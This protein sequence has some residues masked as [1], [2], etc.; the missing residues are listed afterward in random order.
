MPGSVGAGTST[1]VNRPGGNHVDL[2]RTLLPRDYLT[3][4]EEHGDNPRARFHVPPGG[5]EV[6]LKVAQV[7]HA[8]AL[9]WRARRPPRSGTRDGAAFGLS[10][11]VWNDCMRGDRWMRETV[12]AAVL[13]HLDALPRTTTR[14]DQRRRGR[15]RGRRAPTPGASPT[16]AAALENGGGDSV[17]ALLTGRRTSEPTHSR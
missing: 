16:R 11:T 6:S 1:P 13:Y 2:R 4:P 9:A 3:D 17:P 7:Q 14:P 5:D 15:P 10:S 12:M 8:L